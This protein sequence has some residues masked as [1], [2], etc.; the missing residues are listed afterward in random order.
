MEHGM[1]NN[2]V[3]LLCRP[4]PTAVLFP[5]QHTQTHWSSPELHHSN[6]HVTHH[7]L[8][9]LLLI[10]C[11]HLSLSLSFSPGPM[12]SMWELTGLEQLSGIASTLYPSP[13]SLSA[14]PIFSL[15][16]VLPSPDGQY[17]AS[18]SSDGTLFVWETFSGGGQKVKS[19]KEHR[20]GVL[21]MCVDISLIKLYTVC[22][23][24][25]CRVCIMCECTTASYNALSFKWGPGFSIN[26]L[27][28]LYPRS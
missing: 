3:C 21:L 13:L 15:C 8:P 5:W 16:G 27:A 1:Q 2:P 4:T 14:H 9:S 20:L 18:G 24:Y 10:L 11:G 19:R 22:E 26:S 6:F 17:V 23:V 7:L 25:T 28:V 12:D